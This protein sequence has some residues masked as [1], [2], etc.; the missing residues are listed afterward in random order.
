MVVK[1]AAKLKNLA[2]QAVTVAD[3]LA[4]SGCMPSKRLRTA[5]R[6][7]RPATATAAES[8][9]ATPSRRSCRV[10][11]VTMWRGRLS[12]ALDA[13]ETAGRGRARGG[14][15]AQSDGDHERPIAHRRPASDPDRRRDAA[16][17]ELPDHVPEQHPRLRRVCRIGR[18]D[19]DSHRRSG[20]GRQWT[21]TT[22]DSIRG[23]NG[24]LRNW[25][26]DWRTH[27][28][29]TSTTRA[30]RAPT[31]RPI[32]RRSG[33]AAFRW[34]SRCWRR[35]GDVDSRD[36]G[37]PPPRRVVPR[38]RPA[39]TAAAR[40]GRRPAGGVLA[41]RRDP[42][43]AGD[44]RPRR[45][46][47]ASS[48]RSN[49]IR[50]AGLRARSRRCCETARPYGVSKALAEVLAR[51][52]EHLEANERAEVARHIQCAAG[53]VRA[54]SAGV[55]LAHRRARRRI[56]RRTSTGEASPS[57]SLMIRMRRLSDRFAKMRRHAA[58]PGT[59]PGGADHLCADSGSGR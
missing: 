57:A 55:R 12:V 56:S 25:C 1:S 22:V 23:S 54:R 3:P 21:G 11:P 4:F 27:S 47:S 44:R 10:H 50:S 58:T 32:G 37:Y 46:G 18:V 16:A 53:A 40:T 2:P 29:P 45:S 19:G 43:R 59:E 30:C 41:D 7:Q 26:A 28:H 20:A 5:E 42:R 51:T 35:R 17:E 14:G 24:W 52:R 15:A 9:T 39:A 33:S 36:P 48:S 6:L 34:R 38:P 31:R 13:L 49:E 8:P